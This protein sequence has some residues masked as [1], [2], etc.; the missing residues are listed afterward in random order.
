MRIGVDLGGTKT[1]AVVLDPAGVEL[2]R[3][4][5]ATPKGYE[6]VVG[7]IAGLVAAI[8]AR[9]GGQASETGPN[10]GVGIPGSLSPATGLVRNAN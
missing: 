5:V 7:G 6:G 8:E 2:A 1:E 4:R 10:I 3:M 9:V